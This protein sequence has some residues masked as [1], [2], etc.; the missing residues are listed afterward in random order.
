MA[1]ASK[2]V[3]GTHEGELLGNPP[4][5]KAVS[6]GVIDIVRQRDGRLVEHWKQLDAYGLMHQLGAIPS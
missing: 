3:H 2:D 5:G 1:K 4:T 6:F